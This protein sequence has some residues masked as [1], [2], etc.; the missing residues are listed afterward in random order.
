MLHNTVVQVKAYPGEVMQLRIVPHD[1]QNS[2]AA[3]L[4]EILGN[5]TNDVS[6]IL[7]SFTNCYM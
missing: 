7:C 5:V 1:E 6:N 2:T 3:L 4:V